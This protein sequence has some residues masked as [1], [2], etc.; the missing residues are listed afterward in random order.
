MNSIVRDGLRILAEQK[1][2]TATSAAMGGMVGGVLGALIYGPV[3]AAIGAAL[4]AAWGG[5]TGAC[6]DEQ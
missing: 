2:H 1:P 6:E 4:L 5:Y 3:G